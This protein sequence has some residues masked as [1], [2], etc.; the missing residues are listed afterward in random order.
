MTMSESVEEGPECRTVKTLFSFDTEYSADSVEWCPHAPC[1]N[2][3]VCGNYQLAASEGEGTGGGVQKGKRLGRILLFSIAA[4]YDL[5]LHQTID[6]AAVL[7]LKWCHVRINDDCLLGVTNA[8]K[9]IEIYKLD[10]EDI[11]LTCIAKHTLTS[12]EDLLILSLDW[13]TGKLPSETPNIVASDSKGNVSLFQLFGN[14]L[15]ILDTWHSHD[16][17]AWIAGFYYWNPNIIF[18]GG[19]DSMFL[20]FDVR[21][22]KEPVS[23]NRSHDAGVTSFHSNGNKEFI[24]VSGR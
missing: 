16:Y 21:V 23:R 15:N 14:R 19:D 8:A 22:G 7:D 17:E 18:S 3:F 2:V 13:S 5:K 10:V 11:R 9:T 12:E 24:C 6:T 20:K 4:E 1:K